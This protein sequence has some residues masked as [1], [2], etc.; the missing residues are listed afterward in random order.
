MKYGDVVKGK[1]KCCNC[2]NFSFIV[3][4][5]EE[6]MV[7]YKPTKLVKAMCLGCHTV[8]WVKVD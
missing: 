6:Y 3:E 1:C 2:V 8:Q 5:K 7:G 4:E